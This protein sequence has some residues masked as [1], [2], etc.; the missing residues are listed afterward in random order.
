MALY[1]GETECCKF[2]REN[3]SFYNDLSSVVHWRFRDIC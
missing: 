1:E 2:G 3:F